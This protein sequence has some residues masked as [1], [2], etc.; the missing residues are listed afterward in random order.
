MLEKLFTKSVPVFVS[1]LV[2][3][4]GGQF[5]Q[6]RW[7]PATLFTLSFTMA[8]IVFAIAAVRILTSYYRMGFEFDTY[9]PPE[10]HLGKLLLWFGVSM[11]IYAANVLDVTL[12]QLRLKKPSNPLESDETP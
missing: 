3:P 5:L 1:T 11:I 12:A 6:K 7:I 10:I 4:G 9:Q 2:Y 8:F